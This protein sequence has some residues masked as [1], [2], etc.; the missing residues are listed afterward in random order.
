[1]PGWFS[2]I[3]SCLFTGK[4]EEN[5][6]GEAAVAAAE[7]RGVETAVDEEPAEP[8]MNTV[9][10]VDALCGGVAVIEP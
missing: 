2:G 6:W 9:K 4:D 10:L 7:A 8:G 1:V 3:D 5:D